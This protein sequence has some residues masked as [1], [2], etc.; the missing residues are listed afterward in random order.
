[1]YNKYPDRR[2]SLSPSLYLQL[3]PTVIRRRAEVHGPAERVHH[4]RVEHRQRRVH[5]RDRAAVARDRDV[6]V[7]EGPGHEQRRARVV[8]PGGG[9]GGPV[10]HRG[11]RAL[12]VREVP[13]NDG[14]E[15]AGGLVAVEGGLEHIGAAGEE[16]RPAVAT[17]A[18]LEAAVED[19]MFSCEGGGEAGG[20]EASE[21]LG[22]TKVLG[23]M[24]T[25]GVGIDKRKMG[26]TTAVNL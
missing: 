7:E 6:A 21:K 23:V 1:M 12:L 10:V 17:E 4:R 16:G 22:L 24:L 25:E 19:L 15:Q 20:R 26:N 14:A 2:Y 5:G 8:L 3:V 11:V 18:S 13:V 9:G